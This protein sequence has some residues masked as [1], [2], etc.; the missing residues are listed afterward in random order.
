MHR[1]IE[2][3]L[4]DKDGTLMDFQQSWGPW[5]KAMIEGLARDAVH[6]EEI[7]AALGVDL[8]AA[9]FEAHSFVIACTPE[10]IVAELKRLVPEKSEAA[11]YTAL[12][13]DAAAFAPVA[14]PG[15]VDACVTMVAQGLQLGL[16]TNDFEE[17]GHLHLS[18]MGLSNHFGPVIGYDSGHGGKPAPDGCLAAAA[19]MGVPAQS[20]MMVGDSRHDL[21]AGRAAGMMTVAVLTGVATAEELRPHADVLLSSAAQIPDYLT[22]G[23]TNG[24]LLWHMPL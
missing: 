3:V 20:C 11:P 24:A 1:V 5:A 15:M 17:M 9:R 8:A 13:P 23:P 4:F 19:Q 18:Q 22:G 21:D 16:V 7:G 10:E 14:V 6:A 12:T 2:A